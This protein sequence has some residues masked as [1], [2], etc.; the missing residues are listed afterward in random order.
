MK[1][2]HCL[3]HGDLV[4]LAR[5][6]P[7][8][9]ATTTHRELGEALWCLLGALGAAEVQGPQ[10]L[11]VS[12]G[13]SLALPSPAEETLPWCTGL[14]DPLHRAALRAL[15]HGS[16]ATFNLPALGEGVQS[17]RNLTL[18]ERAVLDFLEPHLAQAWR[19]IE[20][21]GEDDLCE[22]LPPALQERLSR[23]VLWVDRPLRLLHATDRARAWLSHFCPPGLQGDA[24]PAPVRDWLRE[25]QKGFRG[26]AAFT[27]LLLR[28][29]AERLVCHAVEDPDSGTTL[30]TLTREKDREPHASRRGWGLTAREAEVL[31]WV[32]QGK[33]DP[34]IAV[35]LGARPRTIEKHVE[36]VLAK[37]GVENRTAA[38]LAAAQGGL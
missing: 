32:A 6:L 15:A 30:L 1:S 36:R 2:L 18:R 12:A 28:A 19:Q 34:E 9:Y 38:A 27:D 35:I 21:R 11:P 20:Q 5:G 25:R 16:G 22:R 14:S 26:G 13:E 31:C 3:R 8:L 24:L 10:C 23:A 33:T 37:L 7:R 4:A 17:S 29:G